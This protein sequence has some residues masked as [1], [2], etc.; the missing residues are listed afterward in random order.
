MPLGR[1]S[2]TGRGRYIVAMDIGVGVTSFAFER[3]L[4][5]G[6]GR[7]LNDAG[8]TGT[9]CGCCCCIGPLRD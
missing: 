8:D 7:L 4:R 1:V 3:I 2:W 6:F 5:G 9:V